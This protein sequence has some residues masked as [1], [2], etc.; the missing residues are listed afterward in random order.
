M[1]YL[2]M[3]HFLKL[4]TPSPAVAPVVAPVDTPPEAPA[5]VHKPVVVSKVKRRHV[6]IAACAILA[7][8]SGT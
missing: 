8:G 4:R 3:S 1:T 7:A 5:K 2:R 6:A